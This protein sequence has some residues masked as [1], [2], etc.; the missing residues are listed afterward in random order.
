MLAAPSGVS[1][2]DR[3]DMDR[4]ERERAQVGPISVSYVSIEDKAAERRRCP[5]GAR[6]MLEAATACLNRMAERLDSFRQ[7]LERFRR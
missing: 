5:L 1:G 2:R 4:F 3:R 7:S 6:T